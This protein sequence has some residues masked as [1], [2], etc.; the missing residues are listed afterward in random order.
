[1]K[2]IFVFGSNTGGIHGSGA[3]RTAYKKHGARYGI[4]VGLC[5]DSYAIPTKGINT[6]KFINVVTGDL[7]YNPT[8][9]DSLPIAAVQSYVQAFI[10]FATDRP[11][12]TFK[13]TRIGCGLAG[14]D[15]ADIAP[16]FVGGQ[17]NILYDTEWKDFLTDDSKFWGTY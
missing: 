6:A 14:F 12:L 4:G 2:D 1:M 3:A 5:G 17:D 10:Q 9:G 16:M 7:F 11:D 15:D 8:V 13:V